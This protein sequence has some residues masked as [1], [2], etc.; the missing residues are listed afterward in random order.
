MSVQSRAPEGHRTNLSRLANRRPG[1]R[2]K[3]AL[4]P[5][6]RWLFRSRSAH[7]MDRYGGVESDG[8]FISFL[9][10]DVS[11][12][13]PHPAD[14]LAILPDAASPQT[15]GNLGLPKAPPAAAKAG[16]AT[17]KT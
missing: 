6:T 11:F 8:L 9:A 3:P 1:F 12:G 2:C 15:P 17:E 5:K 16:T 7:R 13:V 4:F 10:H 14:L